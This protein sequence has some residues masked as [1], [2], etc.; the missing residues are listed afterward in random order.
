L[1]GVVEGG[2][3]PDE[4]LK[5]PSTNQRA[6]GAEGKCYWT[7]FEGRRTP[8]TEV[9][10]LDRLDRPLFIPPGTPPRVDIFQKFN[11]GD[12]DESVRKS[13]GQVR[14]RVAPCLWVLRLPLK[15][16]LRLQEQRK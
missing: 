9:A 13:V 3:R 2:G 10:N 8:H 5:I 12:D 7:L 11:E 6:G 14:L 1:G 16:E 15:R 4:E